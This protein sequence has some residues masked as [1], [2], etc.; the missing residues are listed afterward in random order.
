MEYGLVA[1]WAAVYLLLAAATAPLAAAVFRR[2]P[3]EAVVALSFPL[4]A[5]C[6]FFPVYWL[7][8]L[9][10]GPPTVLVAVLALVAVSALATR[11]GPER[12]DGRAFA[13]VAALFLLA[14][15]FLISLR[16]ADPGA[17]PGGGEKFLDFGLLGSLLRADSLPPESMWFAGERVKY[18]YGGHL[19]AASLAE[20]TA[21]PGRFAYNLALA[22]FYATE[23][24]AVYGVCAAVAAGRG[25]PSRGAGLAGAFLFGFAANLFTPFRSLMGLAPAGVARSAESA[26][27][28]NWPTVTIP[29]TG[30]TYWHASRVIPGTITEFPLFGYLNGDLHGHMLSPVGTTVVVAA[31]FVYYRSSRTERT[32]RVGALA[33]AGLAAGYVTATNTWS[34]P[35]ALGVVWLTATFAPAPVWSFLPE[36]HARSVDRLPRFARELLRPLAAL[37]PAGAVG[38]LA[39]A[40]VAPFLPN[41]LFASAAGRALS[42]L[43]ERSGLLA[44][45]LVH[46]G[47]LAV[48]VRRFA[49]RAGSRRT[50]AIGA[51]LW[52]LALAAGVAL[53]LA[54]VALFVP[55]LGV[56]WY[57]LRRDGTGFPTVLLVAGA[58]LSLL[59][60]FVYLKDG[61]AP[62]R[63]NTVFKTYAQVWLLWSLAGGVTLVALVRASGVPGAFGS[64]GVPGRGKLRRRHLRALGVAL[65]VCL[66]STY[67]VLAVG[68]HFETEDAG[69]LDATAFVERYHPEEAGAIA[70]LA[71]RDGRPPVAEAPGLRPYRWRNPA[72]SLTGLPTVAGW[73]H[74]VYYHGQDA[75]DRRVADVRLLYTGSDATRAAMLRKYDVRYVYYGPREKKRYG[76]FAV[77]DDPAVR[78]VHRSGNVTVYGVNRS[79]LAQTAVSPAAFTTSTSSASIVSTSSQWGM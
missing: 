13:R 38:A 33:V 51:L 62:G 76:A 8:Q 71:D 63:M 54:G 58:G 28:L 39:L 10:F 57:F 79:A 67:G 18:Y 74:A 55:L 30:F 70:W 69:T 48:F 4:S 15:G 5:L 12:P 35:T 50:V 45:V 31:A 60:E 6:L 34:L 21:T 7:G 73:S 56:G 22:G 32:R 20:L 1:L 26:L 41:V 53:D 37:L 64:L 77:G 42:F 14:F 3:P 2:F 52:A 44:L 43:P 40:A 17:F 72:S 75:Y 59:V 25:L 19:L 68:T 11:F 46:G 29:E 49:D 9:A 36:R 61:A 23:V 78:P 47:F 24:V 16:A 66:L 27:A 65:L